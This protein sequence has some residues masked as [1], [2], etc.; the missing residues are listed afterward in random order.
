MFRIIPHKYSQDEIDEILINDDDISYI[1][2]FRAISGNKNKNKCV[3]HLKSNKIPLEVN[4]SLEELKNIFK[5][6]ISWKDQ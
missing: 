4:I 1:K 6:Y 2:P 3:I 5:K